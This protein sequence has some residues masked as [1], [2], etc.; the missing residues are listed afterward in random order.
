MSK[1][2]KYFSR[3]IQKYV[4]SS[5]EIYKSA[6][7]VPDCLKTVQK[8]T[9]LSG[10]FQSN[11][12]ET[13][14]TVRKLS[15]C[16]ETFQTVRKIYRLSGKFPDCPVNLQTVRKLSRLSGKFPDCLENFQ[17]DRKLSRLSGNFAKFSDTFQTLRLSE[18][19]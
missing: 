1:V 12:P 9:R 11:Y 3:H 8:I 6:K 17:T 19:F 18:N 15:L 10:T 14:Q 5:H 16:L 2:R 13:F 4:N 7:I